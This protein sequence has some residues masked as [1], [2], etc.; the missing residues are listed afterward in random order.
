MTSDTFLFNAGWLFFAAWIAVIG[1][2]FVAAFGRDLL[3]WTV[4][5][6]PSGKPRPTDHVG[7]S[8]RPA[9]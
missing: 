8:Q 5:P 7:P 1:G 2:V 9:R 6:D 4:Y 3:P